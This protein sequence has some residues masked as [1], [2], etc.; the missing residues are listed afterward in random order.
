MTNSDIE[1][2][3][4]VLADGASIGRL[5]VTSFWTDPSW[6]MLWPGKTCEYVAEQGSL[7]TPRALLDNPDRNRHLKAV[8]RRTGKIV[9]Y[10]RWVL[11]PVA[12][13]EALWPEAV[14]PPAESPEALRQVD[15]KKAGSDW[16]HD[17]S[18][19]GLDILVKEAS[20]RWLKPG[21]DISK[22]VAMQVV[23]SSVDHR[24]SLLLF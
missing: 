5:K 20:G 23:G 15:L 24:R 19:D 17:S 10:A 8:N 21:E 9:G 6:A 2:L 13:V 18:F 11:P 7:R 3:P 4:C 12:G 14:V 22:F 16:H 1:I